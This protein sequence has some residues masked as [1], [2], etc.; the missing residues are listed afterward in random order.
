VPSAHHQVIRDTNQSNDHQ[1]KEVRYVL[2]HSRPDEAFFTGFRLTGA[3][4]PHAYF[5]YM[6]H[7]GVR[8]MLTQRQLSGD[9]VEALQATRPKLVAYDTEVQK[10][11]SVVQDYIKQHYRP[12]GVG[13]LWERKD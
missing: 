1:L 9:L 8:A 5:Y 11:P 6:L 7:V 12:V 3:F 13:S 4:R 2:E 10:L